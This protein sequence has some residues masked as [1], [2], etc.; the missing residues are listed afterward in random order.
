VYSATASPSD[1]KRK[2]LDFGIV[3]AADFS[4][5]VDDGGGAAA[6]EVAVVV[7]FVLSLPRGEK[8][9]PPSRLICKRNGFMGFFGMEMGLAPPPAVQQYSSTAVQQYS[10]TVAAAAAAAAAAR[11]DWYIYIDIC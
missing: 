3:S 7:V 9:N 2:L 4:S 1:E 5:T 10:S 6:A 8:R 11:T